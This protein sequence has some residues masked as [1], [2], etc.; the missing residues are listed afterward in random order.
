MGT[1]HLT[2]AALTSAFLCLGSLA[3]AGPTTGDVWNEVFTADEQR[4]L[5]AIK[6]DAQADA[7]LKAGLKR[8]TGAAPEAL[9]AEKRRF[10]SEWLGRIETFTKTYKP[11]QGQG[12]TKPTAAAAAKQIPWLAEIDSRDWGG[13]VFP[14][15]FAKMDAYELGYNIANLRALTEEDRK[16][17]TDKLGWAKTLGYSADKV[18]DEM[19]NAGRETMGTVLA[20]LSSDT[21]ARTQTAK[22]QL[23]QAERLLAS[24]RGAAQPGS[25]ADANGAA[26]DG[27]APKPGAVPTMPGESAPVDARNDTP[28]ASNTPGSTL[29]PPPLGAGVPASTLPGAGGIDDGEVPPPKMPVQGEKSYAAGAKGGGGSSIMALLKSPVGLAGIGGGILGAVAGFFLMGGPL[30]AL[31]GF[32]IGAA[33]GA[34]LVVASSSKG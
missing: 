32:F 29:T 21:P 23:E 34:G 30:G 27:T 31:I 19:V 24:A 10:Q 18:S 6:A 26:F 3:H 9:E 17:M 1:S 14:K 20:G 28:L 15:I 5:Y 13:Q 8:V 4:I 33:A 2:K 25:A 22:Q 12:G 7:A 16:K 11:G